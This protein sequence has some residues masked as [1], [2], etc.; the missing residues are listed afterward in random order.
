L[1]SSISTSM[2]LSRIDFPKAQKQKGKGGGNNRYVKGERG[3]V[4]RVV[5]NIKKMTSCR[6]S[7]QQKKKYNNRPKKSLCKPIRKEV[8][9]CVGALNAHP[10]LAKLAIYLVKVGWGWWGGG[11]GEDPAAERRGRER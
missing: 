11:K 3:E 10:I 7:I 6:G 4:N 1:Y 5:K 8:G 9:S 2:N